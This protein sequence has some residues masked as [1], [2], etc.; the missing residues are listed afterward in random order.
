MS[1]G[2]YSENTA[3]RHQENQEEE[4]PSLSPMQKAHHNHIFHLGVLLEA[5][6]LLMQEPFAHS[7]DMPA[8][9]QLP[10]LNYLGKNPSISKL[11]NKLRFPGSLLWL[12][13]S[14][15][16]TFKFLTT[17]LLVFSAELANISYTFE[18]QKTQPLFAIQNY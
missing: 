6:G 5:L 8:F 10:F 1:C 2:L 14:F 12:Y 17:V 15:Y 7:Q 13:F 18:S 9:F 4:N 11:K 16:E 3:K